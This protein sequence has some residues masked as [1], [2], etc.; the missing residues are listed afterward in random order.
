MEIIRQADLGQVI[1]T[2]LAED[3]GQGDITTAATVTPGQTGRARIT[4]KEP[5]EIVFCGGFMFERV[6]AATG[7]QPQLAS[8]A[9]EGLDWRAARSWRRFMAG[10]QDC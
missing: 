1:Q 6:F 2:A 3:V 8:L 7:S 5:D 4:V 10:S 9:P